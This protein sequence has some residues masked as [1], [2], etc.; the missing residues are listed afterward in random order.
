MALQ[1]QVEEVVGAVGFEDVEALGVFGGAEE[2]DGA[3]DVGFWFEEVAEGGVVKDFGLEFFS[4]HGGEGAE[5]AV[6]G[7][8][9]RG[10][11]FVVF[12]A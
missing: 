3:A 1:V 9:V 10:E 2:V 7:Y 5:A 11:D 6:D 8:V 12:V 4:G